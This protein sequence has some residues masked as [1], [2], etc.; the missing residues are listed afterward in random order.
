[1]GENARPNI[2]L[3][4]PDQHR[5]QD[6]GVAGNAQVRTPNLD[7][8]AAEGLYLPHTYSNAPVTCPA[9]SVLQTGKYPHRSGLRIND[10]RFPTDQPTLGTRLSEA[11]YA[12]AFVGKWHLDGGIR[13]PGFVPPE[14]RLGWK[15]WAANQCNHQYFNTEYFRDDPEPIKMTQYEPIELTDLAIEFLRGRAGQEQPFCLLLGFSPPHDPYIAPPEYM[16]K[17]PPSEIVLRPNFVKGTMRGG[18]HPKEIGPDDIAGYYAAIECIDDQIGRLSAAL[19]ELGLADN[20]LFI[21]TSD[22][23]DMLGSN[24]YILKRKP[25]EESICVPGIF[26]WPARIAPGQTKDAILSWVDLAPTL[27][28]LAGAEPIPGSQGADLSRVLLDPAADGPESAFFAQYMPYPTKVEAGWRGVR[29]KRYTWA[30]HE[31]RPWVLFDNQED[32]YQMRN[33]AEDPSAASL[34]A[35]LEGLLLD[36]IERTGATWD[37]DVPKTTILHLNP[38]EEHEAMIAAAYRECG[39]T[40]PPAQR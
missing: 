5:G 6:I 2:V 9:R 20:T 19:D 14:R 36:W 32:P 12:T 22:H 15:W 37:W 1:M 13:T 17:Y 18:R 7:R 10:M 40:P 35:E 38:V 16:A 33:L 27:L 23:G 24:G 8:L 28:S 4:F 34:R 26:R 31:D 25:Y 30:R 11:G 39:K 29:T 21:F 3:V